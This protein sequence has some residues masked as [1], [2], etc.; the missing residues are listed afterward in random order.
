M[1]NTG[2]EY[3]GI[4]QKVFQS[5]LDQKFVKNIEV[6]HDVTLQGKSTTHQID[7]Y[8][9]FSDG[10][11]KYATIV[12]A[13]DYN[14]RVSQDK[15]LTFKAVIDDLPTHPKG[16]FVTKTGY[17][18]GAKAYAEANN[19]LL[20]ELRKPTDKDWEGL[21]KNINI[22]YTIK[23]PHIKNFRIDIDGDWFNKN[24]GQKTSGIK[25]HSNTRETFLYNEKKERIMSLHDL[26]VKLLKNQEKSESSKSIEHVFEQPTYIDCLQDGISL[27]KIKR[28]SFEVSYFIF[29]DMIEINGDDVV[30]FILKNVLDGTRNNVDDYFRV[31]I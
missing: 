1:K 9:E 20:Y 19:I 24:Y 3:E 23:S 25:Y 11:S 29:K 28:I 6:K 4:V 22:N 5:I 7:V 18:K 8:W 16:I 30:K 13:K 17:Q 2:I 27:L 26:I 10:I 14:S 31:H 12:Q 21:I 15:L